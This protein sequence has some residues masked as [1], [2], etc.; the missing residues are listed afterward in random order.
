M[1]A[2][3]ESVT[4]DTTPLENPSI[5][6]TTRP[7]AETEEIKLEQ[8]QVLAGEEKSQRNDKGQFV[9][10]NKL[11]VGNHGGNPCEY[12]QNKEKYQKIADDYLKS[13]RESVKPVTPWIEEL[14][15]LID[16]SDST[17]VNWADKT[18][19]DGKREHPEFFSSYSRLKSLQKL[20]LKQ[21]AL[22]RFTPHGALYLL[23]ADH[24]VIQTNK[25]ILSSDREEPLKIVIVEEKEIPSE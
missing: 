24:K 12:C 22:G 16:V 13:I 1:N 8:P 25:E 15:L 21:R 5:S 17:I 18:D 4:I 2:N 14:A 9:E 19:D 6:T 20:R 3:D 7:E 11:S 23:N 10:G